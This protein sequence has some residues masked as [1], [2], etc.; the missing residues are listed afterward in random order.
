MQL[1]NLFTNRLYWKVSLTFLGVLI[2]L[3]LA[4]VA[5]T[6]YTEQKYFQEANQRLYG[7]IA[8]HLV[9]EVKPT[10]DE[11]GNV[12]DTSMLHDIMHSMMVI[13]PNVEVYLLDT[14][15]RL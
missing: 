13:N 15:G 6:V 12:S 4:Y 11:N 1:K 14:E 2:L 7:S 5:V 10:I 9:Q 3:G 8:Q